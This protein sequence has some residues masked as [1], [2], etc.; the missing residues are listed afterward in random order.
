[1]QAIFNIVFAPT[2]LPNQQTGCSVPGECSK[3]SSMVAD[4]TISSNPPKNN[5]GT[6][7]TQNNPLRTVHNGQTSSSATR[8]RMHSR[9]QV[10]AHQDPT[11]IFRQ[12][13][14]PSTSTHGEPQLSRL[15]HRA[16]GFTFIYVMPLLPACQPV[17][18]FGNLRFCVA[19]TLITRQYPLSIAHTRCVT[20]SDGALQNIYCSGL[21]R[22][23]ILEWYGSNIDIARICTSYI[24]VC[25]NFTS[26]SEIAQVFSLRLAFWKR[27]L[28][29][30]RPMINV[31]RY[32]AR[33]IRETILEAAGLCWGKY[34]SI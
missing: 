33:L 29:A 2:C 4:F 25:S 8:S 24:L 28:G 23:C 18:H 15:Q 11:R 31:M 6:H 12:V 26:V 14:R 20:I 22:M 7:S 21:G 9:I 3:L 13:S 19:C 17:Q 5:L 16:Y 32:G 34:T 10:S 30:V 1:M 27:V